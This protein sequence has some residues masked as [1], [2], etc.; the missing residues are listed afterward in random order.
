MAASWGSPTINIT[1]GSA[2]T[3]NQFLEW[4]HAATHDWRGAERRADFRDLRLA[5]APLSWEQIGT[6]NCSGHLSASILP[7]TLR[8]QV[9]GLFRKRLYWL[10]KNGLL[11]G[12]L[13]A[14]RQTTPAL[15]RPQAH[16]VDKPV[17]TTDWRYIWK[18]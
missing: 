2:M 15:I 7:P 13:R 8:Q 1:K 11:N 18:H 6:T 10:R 4:S 16:L 17:A 3:A 14:G 9:H 12:L 5:S